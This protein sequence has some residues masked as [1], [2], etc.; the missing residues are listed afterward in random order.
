MTDSVPKIEIE[1]LIRQLKTFRVDQEF[2][3]E[4]AQALMIASAMGLE[5]Q[6]RKI[7][8]IEKKLDK[9]KNAKD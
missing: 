3:L 7:Y 5:Q 8:T 2:K 6:Q 1:A 9:I 4:L